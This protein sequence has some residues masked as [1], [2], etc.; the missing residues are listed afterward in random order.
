MSEEEQLLAVIEESR[1]EKLP[2]QE[3]SASEYEEED[4]VEDID[5]D[6]DDDVSMNGKYSLSV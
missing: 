4:V 1:K 6:I 3:N 5:D 2:K